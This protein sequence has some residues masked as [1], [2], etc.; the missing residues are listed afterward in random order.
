MPETEQ[1]NIMLSYEKWKEEGTPDSTR[2]LITFLTP[3]IDSA[4][5]TFSPGM[6]SGLRLKAQTMA[7]KALKTYDP[8]KG[9]HLK[10]YVYQQ[11]QPIQREY[12][13]RLNVTKLP[14]RHIL[15]RKALVQSENEFIETNGRP[16]STA[17]LADFTS[18]PLKRIA[19]I[20]KHGIPLSE[21]SRVH[22]ETGD[23]MISVKQ[24]PQE[25]WADF[26]YADM[27]SIDQR[28]YEM[29]TG[30]GGV[31]IIPKKD[32]AATLKISPAAVSQRISKI[33][34]RLQEGANL[35]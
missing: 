1:D 11:L 13:K 30:Y 10:S 12:G 23:S 9:M 28:I 15:E 33:V 4:L 19:A 2:E 16:P 3:Q 29:C 32:I 6:E 26:V 27:D 24:D 20:R 21:S 18:I 8:T 35:G 5:K 14:E 34:K 7:M 31:D 25:M 22:P 17:E